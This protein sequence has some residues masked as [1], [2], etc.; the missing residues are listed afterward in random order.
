MDWTLRIESAATVRARIARVML[1]TPSREVSLGSIDLKPHQAS[2]AKRIASAL[3]EFGGALLCDQ[4]GMGKTFVALA[5]ARRFERTLIVGPAALATMW[6]DALSRSGVT[7]EFITY[8][9]M[10]RSDYCGAP[11]ELLILDEAHHARN[12]RTQRF[13]RI[14]RLARNS[15]VLMLTA[16]PVHNRRADL[17]ALLSLFLGSRAENLTEG[18]L[19]RCVIRRNRDATGVGGIPDVE[20]T[21]HLDV[22]DDPEVARRLMGLPPPVP[23][24]GGGGGGTLINL[25]LVHQWASSEAALREA[26]R[27]RIANAAALIASLSAGRYPSAT[28]LQTW[29]FA[30]GVLQLGFAELLAP[31]EP[32]SGAL[33]ESVL[34]HATALEHFQKFCAGA[35]RLDEARSRCLLDIRRNNPRSKIV[36]FA[37][38]SSTV[39]ALFRLIGFEGGV[40]MLTA[41]GARVSGGKLSRQETIERF[42]P[43]ANRSRPPP[44]AESIDVLLCTDLLSEGVNLQDAEI[45]IH[46]DVPW[47][48]A[49]MEQRVGRVARM[50]SIHSRVRTYQLRPPA[51]ADAVLRIESVVARKWNVA[52]S[53]IGVNPGGP[54]RA[55][56]ESGESPS[57]IP[58]RAEKLRAILERWR[59]HESAD[60]DSAYDTVVAAVATGQTGFVAA[61]HFRGSPLLLTCSAGAISV[62]LEPQSDA[63]I[64]AECPDT[65]A[66]DA[67]FRAACGEVLEWI[68]RREAMESAGAAV[69]GP[70]RR[71]PILNRIDEILQSSPPH[72]RAYR[73]PAAAD[74]R[75]VASAPHGAGIEQELDALAKSPLGDDEWLA[76]IAAI[77]SHRGSDPTV[78]KTGFQLRALLLFMP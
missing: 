71:R 25:G 61:L 56:G 50:G 74:A 44:R 38:Y 49:R 69:S 19:S 75:R 28:E 39:S 11:G 32:D 55:D 30:D 37:Q 63:C 47:T 14:S 29:T 46:L 73:A 15:R 10:S 17:I 36:A 58:A 66:R 40:A 45:V 26:L 4:V 35:S 22:P 77:G 42:A 62:D 3:D 24:R 52:R 72:L 41:S 9:R 59:S 54:A 68:R 64:L 7:S 65:V 78:A 51:S 13:Q 6:R 27:R 53:S 33:L 70:M 20:P 60:D 57:S 2:S 31:P 16:T 12:P 34:L 43:R 1:G 67:D 21:I 76:A 48:A 8:E 23:V 5:V 18:E